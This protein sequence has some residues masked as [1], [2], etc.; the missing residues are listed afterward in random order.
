MY[1]MLRSGG[2]TVSTGRLARAENILRAAAFAP[3][4]V[5][6][7]V[8]GAPASGGGPAGAPLLRSIMCLYK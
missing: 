3:T 4:G 1:R 5:P 6:D 7:S 8:G 2:C